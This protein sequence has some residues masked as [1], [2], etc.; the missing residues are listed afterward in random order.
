MN[1]IEVLKKLRDTG[2]FYLTT[3]DAENRPKARPYGFIMDYGGKL[4]FTTNENKPTYKQIME[5]PYVELVAMVD[6]F[7]WLRISGKAVKVT[8]EE[9]CGRAVSEMPML[10]QNYAA[11]GGGF[12]VF[13]LDEAVADYYSFDE[14]GGIA[15]QSEK[16]D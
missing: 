7:G 4:C 10:S 1:R 16:L 14:R 13:A 11:Y 9:A 3:V 8:S 6:R 2:T 12:E 5:N 15:K